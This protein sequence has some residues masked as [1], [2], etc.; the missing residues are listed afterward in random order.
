MAGGDVDARDAAVLPD[1]EGQLGGG[2]EGL[3]QPHG[4]A[5]ARHDPGGLPGEGVG[6]VAAVEAD[7]HAPLDSLRALGQNHLGE[8]LGGVAD[9]VD[10]HPVGA[11]PHGAPEAGG[12]ELQLGEEAGLDLLVVVFDGLQFGLLLGGQGGTGQPG[13]VSIT[14][15][16]NYITSCGKIFTPIIIPQGGQD[17]QTFFVR[18]YSNRAISSGKGRENSSPFPVIG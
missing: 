9:D 15:G 8:G 2:A 4:D 5:I 13:L 14:I 6:V 1:G 16:H 18:I 12:T 17:Y 7:G 11:H 10:V 3:E